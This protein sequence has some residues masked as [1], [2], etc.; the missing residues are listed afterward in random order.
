MTQVVPAIIPYSKE[1]LEEEIRKVVKF[2]PLVQIDI[3]DGVFTPTK[4]WPYNGRDTEYFDKLRTEEEGW[5]RWE[6][7]E[8][9]V[10]LMVRNPEDV[11]LDWIN[12]GAGAVVCH[13][14]ATENFQKI[15]DV[16]REH[17]V[18]VGIALK[19]STD[20][21]RIE[22]FAEQVDFIQMMG[23]DLLGKHGVTLDQNAVVQIKRLQAK[24]PERIIS[25]DIGVSE[26]TESTLIAAGVDKFISGGAILNAENPEEVYREL[27]G[28]I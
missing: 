15:I 13:I 16:C 6:D 10:H 7:L 22:P 25:I 11:L 3:S 9:E 14:E 26:E 20:I 27:E 5:P 4:T 18:A 8:F 21:E 12:T 17:S 23:S 24:Y 2:A 19:P 28:R 1:Q